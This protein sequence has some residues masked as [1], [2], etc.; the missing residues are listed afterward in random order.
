MTPEA[1][2]S[3]VRARRDLEEA[4]TIAALKLNRLASRSAYYAA[5]HAAEALILDRTGRSAKTHRGVH[6]EFSRL[7][8][9]GAADR[10]VWRVLFDG[11]RYKEMADYSTDPDATVSDEAAGQVIADAARFVSRVTELLAAPPSDG[12]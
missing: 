9:D 6:S 2:A 1:V 4:R 7:T 10:M 12:A 11:Y 8:R 5:F 3:L